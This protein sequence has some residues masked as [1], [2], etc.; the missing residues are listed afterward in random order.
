MAPRHKRNG[1]HPRR[2]SLLFRRKAS[3]PPPW[4]W[5]GPPVPRPTS[6]AGP[7]LF[8]DPRPRKAPTWPNAVFLQASFNF[9]SAIPG[10]SA[11]SPADPSGM[12][13]IMP[14]IAGGPWRESTLAQEPRP[15]GGRPGVH[16]PIGGVA[17]FPPPDSH[18]GHRPT[19]AST[20][21]LSRIR[22][23]TNCNGLRSGRSKSRVTATRSREG[24]SRPGALDPRRRD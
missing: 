4:G 8:P 23:M 16:S 9:G 21:S 6:V 10:Q 19:R 3:A 5:G 15:G 1:L 13:F 2:A 18:Q 12:A 22:T 14:V 11:P 7:V 24:G 20:V 17:A